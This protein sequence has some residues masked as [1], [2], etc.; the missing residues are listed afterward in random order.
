VRTVWTP[1]R[2]FSVSGTG[3]AP[4]GQ[5]HGDDGAAVS[6][7]ADQALRW[8][9]TVGAGCNDA[10]LVVDEG[11][12]GIVGDPTEGALLAVAAKAGI[13]ADDLAVSCPRVATT[14]FSSERQYMATV[15]QDGDDG[16]HVVLVKG[17]AERVIAM[18]T[19]ELGADGSRRPVARAVAMQVTEQLAADGL[20]VLGTAYARVDGPE[21][22]D[23]HDLEGRLVLTGLQ[24]MLDPPR[25]AAAGAVQAF[26]T[27][28]ITV[29]MITGDHASTATAIA[30][31][32]GLLHDP[33]E[34]QDVLTGEELEVL[35]DA[36][37]PDAVE[38]ASVFAR[39]SPAQKL[40]LVKAMQ[41]RRH[42]IAMTGDGVNDAPALRQ[43]DIGIAMG[44]S[45]TEVAK[46]SADM[47]LTDDDFATIEA[48]VEEGRGVCDNL[49]KFI[50]W[51]LPT[52][53]GEGMIVLVAILLGR[54]LPILPTQILWINMTTA[55][56]LGL[57][58]AFEPK[59]ADV[60]TRPPRDPDR[61]LLTRALVTR[62]LLVSALVVA[63]S[64]WVF[65]AELRAGASLPEARTAAVSAVVATQILYLFSCRSLS[66]A[67]WRLGLLSN[68]WVIG[69]VAL[70]VLAQLCL[71]YLAAL[72]S[73][74]QTA[75]IGVDA[76]L[77][78]L[79][80][81]TLASLVIAVDKRFRHAAL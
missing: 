23:E 1:D 68:P 46:E 20:R 74:F 55:V 27:A 31:Q 73:L 5:V 75:P 12:H 71:T 79:L 64:W 38:R 4:V 58:L 72:N 41:A 26:H 81:A 76:W 9:L 77:R 16:G 48:A 6:A 34:P 19:A 45:G 70:Q 43:A 69:G 66:R 56:L 63:A 30:G 11:E 44:H 2:P 37:Y 7:N 60:M 53:V 36:D 57:M 61:P 51:T 14:P 39:V 49:T 50:V 33:V 17:A 24:A 65:E 15:H 10:T 80:A 78:I 62:V 3:Y 13:H 35:S 47:V 32:L 28:G 52:N 67:A 25:A 59:E 42:V 18:C 8:S 22:V 21:P 40:R 54:Q 29:K